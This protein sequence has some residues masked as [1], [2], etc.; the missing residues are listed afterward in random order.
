MGCMAIVNPC[1]EYVPGSQGPCT[2]PSTCMITI[3]INIIV[4]I[5]CDRPIGLRHERFKDKAPG[6]IIY[7]VTDCKTRMIVSAWDSSDTL[8]VKQSYTPAGLLKEHFITVRY[9]PWQNLGLQ[10]SAAG[11]MPP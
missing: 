4:V 2:S 1:S 10:V 7:A 6:G 9:A 5:L 3:L 11:S 8:Q